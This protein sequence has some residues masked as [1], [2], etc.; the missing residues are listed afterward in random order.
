LRDKSE[1]EIV[2]FLK[3]QVKAKLKWMRAG[4]PP[5]EFKITPYYKK[6]LKK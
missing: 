3:K 5:G 2:S 4:H 6:H 1:T